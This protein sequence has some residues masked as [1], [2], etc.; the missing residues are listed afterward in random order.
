M[1]CR[2]CALGLF[3]P[4]QFYQAGTRP[5]TES[6]NLNLQHAVFSQRCCKSDYPDPGDTQG[7][8]GSLTEQYGIIFAFNPLIDPNPSARIR[9]AQYARNLLMYA[10]KEADLGHQANAPFRDPLFA[11]YTRERLG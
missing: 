7:Y 3:P 5:S 8:A 11:I 9:Y 10:M 1:I 2:A 6:G 4:I